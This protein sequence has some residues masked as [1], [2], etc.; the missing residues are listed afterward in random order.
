MGPAAKLKLAANADTVNMPMNV[1]A[2]SVFPYTAIYVV[3]V[4]ALA[5]CKYF[6]ANSA[7]ILSLTL[8]TN[9]S[10][11]EF[12]PEPARNKFSVNHTAHYGGSF[13]GEFILDVLGEMCPLPILR[14]DKL[15]KTLQQG[16]K[17]VVVTDHSCAMKGIPLHFKKLPAEIQIS[18]AAKGIWKITIE[19]KD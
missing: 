16:D 10:F 19:K 18:Q 7:G 14:S 8:N 4:A 5:V 11:A 12:P 17:L 2:A 3:E 1:I 13:M 15:F 9:H 6:K